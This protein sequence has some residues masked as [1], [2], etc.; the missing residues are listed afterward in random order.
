MLMV[1]TVMVVA[2]FIVFN[3]AMLSYLFLIVCTGLMLVG[4]IKSAAGFDPVAYTKLFTAEYKLI[5]KICT[6]L[7]VLSLLVATYFIFW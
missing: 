5:F 3:L 6:Y 2:G 4:R 7:T 1:D